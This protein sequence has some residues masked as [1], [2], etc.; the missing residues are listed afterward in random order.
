MKKNVMSIKIVLT[1]HIK[2]ICNTFVFSCVL[3][4]KQKLEVKFYGI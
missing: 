1:N 2:Y 4:K 3:Q